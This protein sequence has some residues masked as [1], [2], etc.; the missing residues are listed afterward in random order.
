M[1]K[2]ARGEAAD[3]RSTDEMLGILER[4]KVNGRIPAG[5]PPG[6][7]VAHKTGE[8][9]KIRH[10]A[11]IVFTPRPFVLVVL[12]RGLDDGQRADSLIAAIAKTVYQGQAGRAGRGAG[13]GPGGRV[14]EQAAARRRAAGSR[15]FEARHPFSHAGD[16][17]HRRRPRPREW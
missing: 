10:D 1:Q 12:V 15:A 11:A 9:T 7:P 14:C 3:G 16:V 5:L 4:Q 13:G 2:I 6:I 17:G 8:I